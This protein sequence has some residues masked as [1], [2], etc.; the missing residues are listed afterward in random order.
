M[1][2]E[3]YLSETIFERLLD[4]DVTAERHRCSIQRE[5]E[6]FYNNTLTN[7]LNWKKYFPWKRFRTN[8]D[9]IGLPIT[10][11]IIEKI[12]AATRD[13]VTIESDNQTRIE[14]M[15]TKYNLDVLIKKIMR[16]TLALGQITQWLKW[17]NDNVVIE[18]WKPWYV[19]STKDGVIKYYAVH[20]GTMIPA[21][22]GDIP[23][24]ADVFIEYVTSDTWTIWQNGTIIW[25]E[26]HGLPYLPI[27]IWNNI[28]LWGNKWGQP[29]SERFK[30]L[31]IK[32]NQLVSASHRQILALPTVWTTTK[33]F[34]DDMNPLDI[35]PDYINFVG[36]DKD[37]SQTTRQ[38]DLTWESSF[39]DKYIAQIYDVAQMP[40]K[41]FLEGAG[42]VE[43]GIALEIVYKQFNELVSDIS[44]LFQDYEE[45]LIKKIYFMETG[46]ELNN[47]Q[48]SYSNSATPRNEAQEFERDKQLLEIGVYTLEEFTAK[49]K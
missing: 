21:I 37:L 26:T 4:D 5:G 23:K 40:P 6:V 30:N 39:F 13:S 11:T 48:I 49:W 12:I 8:Q 10:K 28:D 36:S 27:Q 33:D 15:Y 46:Q 45:E 2:N 18:Q 29:F 41:E 22:D 7:D 17:D 3:H 20:K 16:E 43:S 35:S 38:L 24:G 47:I 42:K 14:E 9:I 1:A 44:R 34:T 19:F 32:L 31:L 25:D